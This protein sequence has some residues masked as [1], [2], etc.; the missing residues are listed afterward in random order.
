[1]K[2]QWCSQGLPGLVSHPPTGQNWGRKWGKIEEKW[3]KIIE[4]WGKMRNRLLPTWGWESG[5]APV[6]LPTVVVFKLQ[7]LICISY[8]GNSSTVSKMISSSTPPKVY[9]YKQLSYW[10]CSEDRDGGGVRYLCFNAIYLPV[11]G[12]NL[13]LHVNGH[14]AQVTHNV[15]YLLDVLIHL[16]FASILGYPAMKKWH[17]IEKQQKYLVFN[18][19]QWY[20]QLYHTHPD[21]SDRLCGSHV[22]QCNCATAGCN[23]LKKLLRCPPRP[24]NQEGQSVWNLFS[25]CFFD[26]MP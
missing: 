6:K 7:A 22:M 10:D 4:E 9:N 1:M 19:K 5:Y 16:I 20:I 3:V 14:V 2:L 12:V 24:K 17:K 18:L 25:F 11:L 26:T 15:A 21:S 23:S 8:P 13:T